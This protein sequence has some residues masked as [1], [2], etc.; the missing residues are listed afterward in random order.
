MAM[1]DRGTD[2]CDKH[3]KLLRS[4]NRRV[5]KQNLDE[6]T[7]VVTGEGFEPSP[8]F[9]SAVN[10]SVYPCLNDESEAC[11][12]SA[13]RL[14]SALVRSGRVDDVAPVV[15]I[16]HKRM[17]NV[18]VV[19]SSE[20]VKLLYVQLLKDLV[21]NTGQRSILPC[22]DD[23]AGVLTKSVLDACPAVKKESCS[24]IVELANA[25]K[26]QFHMIAETF[27]EPLLKTTNYHQWSV[28]YAAIQSLSNN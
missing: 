9:M 2:A 7:A 3:F 23:V 8:E 6:L 26:S 27:V 20:E 4:E 18:A 1:G 24:C 25:T 22:L 21:A 14:V 28:R 12:V 16:V 13:I 17:G 10:T 15:F 11:R 19:E 5:R